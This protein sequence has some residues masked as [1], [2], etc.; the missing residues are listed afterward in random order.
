MPLKNSQILNDNFFLNTTLSLKFYVVSKMSENGD[1]K[2]DHSEE[3]RTGKVARGNR[4][5]KRKNMKKKIFCVSNA[6]WL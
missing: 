3:K 1:R 5:R 4:Q 2:I 6:T